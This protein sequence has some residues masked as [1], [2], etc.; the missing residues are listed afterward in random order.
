MAHSFIALNDDFFISPQ[1]A[2]ADVEIAKAEGVG[3][4]INNRPDGEG[5]DQPA[6]AEIAAAAQ[7]AGVSYVAIPVGPAGL[8]GEHLDAFMTAVAQNDGKKTLGFCKSGMRSLM[9]RAMA[10]ARAGASADALIEEAAGAGFD[11]SGHRSSLE[12]IAG[13]AQ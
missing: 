5:P 2:A 3:L 7:A 12:E 10:M 11:I 4:I 1:I 6:G 13:L 8:S 9:V